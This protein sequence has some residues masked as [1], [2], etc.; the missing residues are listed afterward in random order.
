MAHLSEAAEVF[1]DKRRRLFGIAYRILGT[2]A[3]AEDVVQDAWLRWQATDRSVVLNPEAFLV[4]TVTRLA[5]NVATSARARREHYVGPWLPEPVPTGDDDPFLGAERSEA[6]SVAMLTL[7]ERLP[8]AERAVYVLREAFDYPFRDI[9]E[10]LR[11]SEANA[12]QLAH[13]A[14][15]HLAG[16]RR[17][18]AQREEMSRLLD[19]FQSASSSG[20]LHDLEQL[21]AEDVVAISDGG[22]KA[23]AAR[24]PVTGRDR[25]ARFLGSV[26]RHLGPDMTLEIIDAN[27]EPCLVVKQQTE[28]ISLATI[29]TDAGKI[30]GIYILRNPDK[31]MTAATR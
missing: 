3:D 1:E 11:T 30:D 19:A 6:L 24:R 20:N 27:G 13:R 21:L 18:P 23:S 16:R 15:G 25:V 8:P 17:A 10:V 26:V 9:A 28:V 7:M 29:S 2:V 31:L 4:T 14:R 12:R 5:I 22:G